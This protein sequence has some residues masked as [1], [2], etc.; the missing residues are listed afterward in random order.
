M[1]L[2]VRKKV[3]EVLIVRPGDEVI[4]TTGDDLGRCGDLRQKVTQQR[5]CSG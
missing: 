3:V 4:V 1:D 2:A 5:F